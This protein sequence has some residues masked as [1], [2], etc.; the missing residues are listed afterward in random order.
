MDRHSRK[1]K[2]LVIP[3]PYA[4]PYYDQAVFQSMGTFVTGKL[5][6]CGLIPAH[7]PVH[8]IHVFHLLILTVTKALALKRVNKTVLSN[9][10]SVHGRSVQNKV[11]GGEIL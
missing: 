9:Q 7:E 2:T 5:S 4:V 1:G 10:R 6:V 3:C 11:W 8:T